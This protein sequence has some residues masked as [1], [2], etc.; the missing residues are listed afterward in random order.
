MQ[1]FKNIKIDDIEY[2]F[3]FLSPSKASKLLSKIVRS[4][5]QPIGALIGGSKTNDKS[6]I[7]DRDINFENAL[8]T[9]SQNLTE[10]DFNLII[11]ELLS[12]VNLGTGMMINHD[13]QFTG[14]IMHMYK[15]AYKSFEVNY[16]DFLDERSGIVAFLRQAFSQAK[17]K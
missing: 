17:Q 13:Q 5:L 12:S 9:L 15:V 14:K 7:L 1:G 11:L 3:G 4:V 10:E 16:S 8:G 2:Q 6:G